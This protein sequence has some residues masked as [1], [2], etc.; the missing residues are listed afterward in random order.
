MA[1]EAVSDDFQRLIDRIEKTNKTFKSILEKDPKQLVITSDDRS[2]IDTIIGKNDR[3]LGKLRSK[4]FEIAVVGLEKAGKS[5]LSNALIRVN[6][7]PAE[8]ERCTF[9]KT[10]IRSGNK[11]CADV[12]FY[13]TDEFNKNFASQLKDLGY[14]E[15]ALN[16][17]SWNDFDRFWKGVEQKDPSKY[18]DFS[19]STVPDI[20]TMAK[21]S[22]DILPYL[23]SGTRSFNENEIKTSEFKKFITGFKEDKKDAQSVRGGFPYAVKSVTIWSKDLGDDMKTAVL[24]DVPGFDSPTQLHRQQTEKTLKSADAIIFVSN[25]GDRPNLTDPQV[26]MLRK[27]DVD[28]DGIKLADKAFVF[29]NKLDAANTADNASKNMDTLKQEVV[30]KYKIAQ[31]GRVI[32]GSAE[33]FLIEEK[34]DKEISAEAAE[35]I[36]QNIKRYNNGNN[37]IQDLKKA[38]KDYY[39][40]DRFRVM[41]NRAD[42][43]ENAIRELLRGILD[44][45]K[46][47]EISDVRDGDLYLQVH[48][49]IEDFCKQVRDVGKTFNDEIRKEHPFTNKLKEQINAGVNPGGKDKSGDDSC[50]KH[51]SDDELHDAELD[52]NLSDSGNEGDYYVQGVD[53]LLRRNIRNRIRKA[54]EKLVVDEI[55]RESDELHRRIV[56]K[57]VEC[58][59][60]DDD[61]EAKDAAEKAADEFIREFDGGRD[62][63]AEF[64]ALIERFSGKLIDAVINKPFGGDNGER[65][66]FINNNLSEFCMLANYY[67]FS[68]PKTEDHYVGPMESKLFPL[69][70][71]H[72]G[73]GESGDVTSLIEQFV[74]NPEVVSKAGKLGWNDDLNQVSKSHYATELKTK[75]KDYSYEKAKNILLKK[76]PAKLMSVNPAMAAALSVSSLLSE[77]IDEAN[78]SGDSLPEYLSQLAE[79]AM[80]PRSKTEL[81]SILDADID[82]LKDIFDKSIAGAIDLETAFINFNTR[83]IDFICNSVKPENKERTNKWIVINTGKLKKRQFEEFEDRRN[84]VSVRKAI[85]KEIEEALNDAA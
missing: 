29:G 41:K 61:D 79:E 6:V 35:P 49:A 38:L 50:F 39:D 24:L 48:N 65:L 40:N 23:G 71:T 64:R 26:S 10:E 69:I 55:K 3:L 76:L 42:N 83:A 37:G 32:F 63:R 13:S 54:A 66:A 68:S 57:L 18:R 15:C 75:L 60:P 4:E 72:D 78:S 43:N 85:V 17:F 77:L 5:T 62:F 27:S 59:K 34:L 51:V 44:K 58:L 11:N 20:E 81:R 45:C 30:F 80:P 8:S 67:N 33:A 28:D 73:A 2:K 7:L 74:N 14:K 19:T 53:T 25:V 47:Q 70:I 1:N 9:T 36:I 12:E 84:S 16:E 46:S 21:N 56:D 82:C 22:G 31:P 52:Q